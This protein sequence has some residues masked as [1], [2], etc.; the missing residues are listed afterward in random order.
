MSKNTKKHVIHCSLDPFWDFHVKHSEL[1]IFYFKVPVYF[2]YGTAPFVV[3]IMWLWFKFISWP[4]S[5][6]VISGV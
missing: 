1:G 4:V 6:F 2:L 5:M 3:W